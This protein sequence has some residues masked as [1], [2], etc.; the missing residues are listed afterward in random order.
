MLYLA[1]ATLCAF[2]WRQP[3]NADPVLFVANWSGPI[4]EYN[5][6]GTTIN[7]ALI[8][9][10]LS[11]EP[12]GIA[13]SG[14]DIFVTRLGSGTIQEYTTSG[15]TVNSSLVSGLNFYGSGS[16]G[17]AVSGS[18][19]FVVNSANLVGAYTTSGATVN[20]AL[21]TSLQYGSAITVSGSDLF[22]TST[23]N[24]TL[25]EYTTSGGAVN[26]SL[27]T[28]LADSQGIVVSGSDIFVPNYFAG[29][30]SEY[31]TSGALV[32]ASLISGLDYPKSIAVY[33]SDIF[34]ANA[35]GTIGEYTT[36]GAT[37]NAALLTGL[38]GG[39]NVIAIADVSAAE[40]V[41]EPASSAALL[42]VALGLTG[43]V[44]AKRRVFGFIVQSE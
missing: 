34:V 38:N 7:A 26:A 19:I 25:G 2:A 35:N 12:G 16:G 14:S 39:P 17:I 4:G 15:A 43:L 3:A 44:S 41:P 9:N 28:T 33:G 36:S 40:S 32:N 11:D 5:L 22:V 6:N 21:I 13:V 23:G 8:P 30:I 31:T 1:A 37:I 10:P 29:T 24:S 18:T 20:A 27:V 42:V